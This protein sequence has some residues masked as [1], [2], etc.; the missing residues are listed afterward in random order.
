[1]ASRTRYAPFAL[2]A[3][4]ALAA[5]LLL[6]EAYL[7]FWLP[8][9]VRGYFGERSGASGIYRPDAVL[10][11]DYRSWEDFRAENAARLNELGPLAS[12]TPT[13]LML[14]N[15]FVQAPGM[16]AETAR[17]ALPERRIF[18][19]GR[20]EI[21]PLRVAQ[22]RLLGQAGLR[23]ERIFFVLLPNDLWQIGKRPL[24]FIAVNG[25]GAIA[26]RMRRP[27]PPWDVAIS[28]SLL[29]S[30]AW[31]RAGRAEGDPAFRPA[32]VAGTPSLRL[33]DDLRR[34]LGEL[35]AVS[36]RFALPVTVVVLPNREQVFGKA[37]FGF[38]N[39]VRDISRTA[40]LDF[41]DARGL[42][43]DEPD[44]PS[45]FAPDWHFSA[46]GNRLL[47]QGLLAHLERGATVAPG[48]PAR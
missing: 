34:L 16:L 6:G 29:A 27:A 21:L 23:P 10:G 32:A 12:A 13:W 7:R 38:Q 47:L 11:V 4:A 45:L 17:A 15:S 3:A 33:Q 43:L 36:R 46:R 5:V 40:G 39:A 41:Y 8:L 31:I 18:Y 25:D 37:P 30:I 1:L 9:D 14:G 42:F 20:N 22:V 28:R 48:T 2:G 19:L 35:A 24:S 26:T 44:K